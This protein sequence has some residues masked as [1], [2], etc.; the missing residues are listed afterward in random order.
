MQVDLRGDAY[1]LLAAHPL[2]PLISLHHLD[3]VKPIIPSAST[4]LDALKT[5]ISASKHDP[6]RILQQT[7]CY[8]VDRSFNWSVSVS[9]GYT[10]QIYPWVLPATE[11]EV[12]LRT[13][14]TWRSYKDGPF[15]FNTRKLNLDQ[16]C[17][18]PVRFFLDRVQ[19]LDNTTSVTEYKKYEEKDGSKVCDQPGFVAASRVGLVRVIARRLNRNFWQKAPRRQCCETRRIK[20][21]KVMEVKIRDCYPG[22]VTSPP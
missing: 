7:F 12:P 5:L 1:G 21:G 14:Q 2:T 19:V 18:R 10:V 6:A 20:R 11:L 16:E 22:E 13:F 3:S 8:V 9:W 17:E 15:L 4:Q